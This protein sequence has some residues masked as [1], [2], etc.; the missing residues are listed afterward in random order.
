MESDFILLLIQFFMRV[1]TSY[2]LFMIVACCHGDGSQ[3][4]LDNHTSGIFLENDLYVNIIFHIHTSLTIS[5]YLLHVLHR[6]RQVEGC[7]QSTSAQ[8]WFPLQ[9]QQ[10]LQGTNWVEMVKCNSASR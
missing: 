1:V 3:L 9:Y 10:R 8:R 2:F 6:R 5:M 7:P 4:Y